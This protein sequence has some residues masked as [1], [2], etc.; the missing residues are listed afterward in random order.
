MATQ[1]WN[2][3]RGTHATN[4]GTS[5]HKLR[6][7]RPLDSRNARFAHTSPGYAL[8]TIPTHSEIPD[9]GSAR[10]PP[11]LLRLLALEMPEDRIDDGRL[12]DEGDDLHL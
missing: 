5:T 12:G 7:T 1:M 3:E 4:T 11:R 10:R 6:P 8:R 9:L 2:C